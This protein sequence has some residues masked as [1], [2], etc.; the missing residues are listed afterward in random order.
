MK[1]LVE[2]AIYFDL[3]PKS[4]GKRYVF[5]NNDF[6]FLYAHLKFASTSIIVKIAMK[7]VF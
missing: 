4:H 7:E 6:Y 2:N 1:G 5:G 3:C